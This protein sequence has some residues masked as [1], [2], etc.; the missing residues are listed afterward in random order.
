MLQ[1]SHFLVITGYGVEVINEKPHQEVWYVPCYFITN[2]GSV[3]HE[4]T[5]AY[6]K[7][8]YIMFINIKIYADIFLTLPPFIKMKIYAEHF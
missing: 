3:F 1:S 7:Y 8:K 2:K 6:D 4:V 5:T